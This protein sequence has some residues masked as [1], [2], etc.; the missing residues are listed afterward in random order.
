MHGTSSHPPL[1]LECPLCLA[2]AE[3]THDGSN[4]VRGADDRRYQRCPNCSLIFV[5]PAH[6]PSLEEERARYEAHENGIEK[7]GYVAFL[8]RVLDPMLPYLQRGMRGLD[9]GSGPRPTLSLL[10]KE[11]GLD[12]EDYDPLFGPRDLD[13]PYDFI[14]STETFEHFRQ[15]ATEVERIHALL[16]PGGLLGIMTDRWTTLQDFAK[17]Y[18]TRDPTHI[19]FYHADTLDFLCTR[20]GFTPIW[21]D[22]SRVA[23]FR[24]GTIISSPP[25][26]LS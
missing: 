23:V 4:A 1:T 2:L 20:F 13:P 11:E 22:V 12:C 8:R 7:P 9:Y 3:R 24:K 17:W 25:P 19:S 6:H 18:Y 26:L 5:D 10:A 21:M 16:K 15:P 14:F